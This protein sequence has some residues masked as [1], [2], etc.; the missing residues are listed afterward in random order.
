MIGIS[1]ELGGWDL[2]LSA[3]S[4]GAKSQSDWVSRFES[5]GRDAFG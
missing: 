3:V 1:L 4:R 5:G 2:E